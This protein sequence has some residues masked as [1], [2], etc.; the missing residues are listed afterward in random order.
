MLET[1]FIPTFFGEKHKLKLLSVEDAFY[2]IT[3]QNKEKMQLTLV[4]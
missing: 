4:D 1:Q 3:G 2:Y